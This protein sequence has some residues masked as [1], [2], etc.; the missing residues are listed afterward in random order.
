M[1]NGAFV[2]MGF[3]DITS[4]RFGFE[5]LYVVGGTNGSTTINLSSVERYD[6]ATNAWEAVAPIDTGRRSL[7][8]ATIDGKL[9]AAGGTDG[10][11]THAPAPSS[12]MQRYDP[13]SNRWKAMASMSPTRYGLG[14][15]ALD[16]KVYAVGGAVSYGSLSSV[17]RYDAATDIWEAVAPMGTKRRAVG[18]AVL[19]GKLHAVGGHDGTT[20][21]SSV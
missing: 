20:T 18:V 1:L 10:T 7:G 12:P 17:E 15:E 6:P 21:L 8:V 3:G 14:V 11:Q 9:Y 13:A 5:R 2:A 16:G 19:D 4:H